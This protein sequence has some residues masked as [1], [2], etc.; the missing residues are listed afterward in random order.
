MTRRG[1]GAL[2]LI[3]LGFGV[4]LIFLTLLQH[5][6]T[7]TAVGQ[8]SAFVLDEVMDERRINFYVSQALRD[9]VHISLHQL[10]KEGLAPFFSSATCPLYQSKPILFSSPTC[11]FSQ[12][13]LEEQFLSMIKSR[14]ETT[15]QAPSY[16]SLKKLPSS[17]LDLKITPKHMDF[18]G[19]FA[20]PLSYQ[21]K[22]VTYTFPITYAESFSYDLH[23]YGLFFTTLTNNIPCLLEH[24]AAS[25]TQCSLSEEFSWD[26][27]EE[28]QLLLITAKT[29]KPFFISDYLSFSFAIS[30][31]NAEIPKNYSPLFGG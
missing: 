20:S 19:S 13:R 28:N 3:V 31:N 16:P 17:S 30:L 1:T 23:E 26:I 8:E 9:A 7:Y 14:W 2:I 24:R 12:K 6:V 15:L 27:K 5:S 10:I 25:T 22:Y 11:T 21:G 4:L 18:S 29:Q